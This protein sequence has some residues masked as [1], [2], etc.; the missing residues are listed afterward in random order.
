MRYYSMLVVDDER[1][2]REYVMNLLDWEKLGIRNIY[3]ADNCF[4]ALS[5]IKEHRPEIIFLDIKMPE[6]SGVDLLLTLEQKNIDAE[7]IFLSGYSDFNLA[8]QMLKS[9]KVVEYLL[10]PVSEDLAAEAVTLAIARIEKARELTEMKGLVG[11]VVESEKKRIYQ[12]H[13]CGYAYE[14]DYSIEQDNL[15]RS[16]QVAVFYCEADHAELKKYCG[17]II[18]SGLTHLQDFFMCEKPHHYALFFASDAADMHAETV[19]LCESICLKTGLCCGLGRQYDNMLELNASYRQ[20]YFSCEF[21]PFTDMRTIFIDDISSSVHVHIDREATA[22]QM[23]QF[24]QESNTTGIDEL[25]MQIFKSVM[26]ESPDVPADVSYNL[27]IA[28]AYFTRFIE[29]LLSER[30]SSLNLSQIFAARNIY[31]LFSVVKKTLHQSCSFFTQEKSIHKVNIVEQV[32]TYIRENYMKQISLDQAAGVVFITASYLSRLFSEVE[33]CGF[34]SYVARLR[35]D[36]AKKLLPSRQYKIYEITE[37]VGYKS[38]KHFL[39]IF[40]ELEGITPA[41]YRENSLFMNKS[42]SPQKNRP[43]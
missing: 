18:A 41:Q 19:K 37:M 28:K 29:T 11:K 20:A 4:S 42:E 14:T 39:K 16:M 23:L 32:K 17:D 10:K 30:K 22:R 33:G 26:I 24:L 36:E 12:A 2:S 6:M 25:I 13:I 15:Y 40:K 31:E 3:E 34:S 7:V 38:F 35:I 8:R 1:L 43:N 21:R 5:I 27:G 9:G